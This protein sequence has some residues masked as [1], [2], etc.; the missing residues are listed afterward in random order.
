MS[1][2][3]LGRRH[4]ALDHRN[5]VAVA[6]SGPRGATAGPARLLRPPAIAALERC[7]GGPVP[8]GVGSIMGKPSSVDLGQQRSAH[9]Q[10]GWPAGSA[11]GMAR[12]RPGTACSVIKGE[13][14]LFDLG[15]R[16]FA[17]DHRKRGGR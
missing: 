8:R 13:L 3:D 9:D 11:P 7:E 17:L 2:F 12:P 4:F 15:R 14:L 1:L 5:L 16:Q 6:G 10:R